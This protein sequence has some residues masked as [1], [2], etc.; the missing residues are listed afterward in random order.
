LLF[1]KYYSQFKNINKNVSKKFFDCKNKSDLSLI[2]DK[3]FLEDFTGIICFIPK[4]HEDFKY[5]FNEIVVK[6]DGKD[7]IIKLTKI[8]LLKLL[9]LYQYNFPP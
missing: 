8:L 9:I 7:L 6:F 5:I 4:N 3:I 1:N 2:E